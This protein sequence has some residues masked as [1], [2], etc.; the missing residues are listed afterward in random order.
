MSTAEAVAADAAIVRVLGAVEAEAM[1]LPRAQALAVELEQLPSRYRAT[2]L[3][4]TDPVAAR[5]AVQRCAV[6]DR[7]LVLTEQDA[8]STLLC[9]AALHYLRRIDRAPREARVVIV[10]GA[11]LPALAQVLLIA[12]VSA[13]TVC[14]EEATRVVPLARIARDAD[15]LIDV[16]PG[17]APAVEAA[18][19]AEDRPEGSVIRSIDHDGRSLVA[20]G[21]LRVASACPPGAMQIV[22]G[23]LRVCA[24]AITDARTSSGRRGLS[25]PEVADAVATALSRAVDPRLNM[26]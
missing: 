2:F 17:L 1:I 16:R 22:P 24:F 8:T 18:R 14:G 11:R 19:I 25:G 3:V 7:R 20:P 23:L 4:R 6:R 10:G 12:G 15:V 21:L 5:E 26:A 13:L 9:A